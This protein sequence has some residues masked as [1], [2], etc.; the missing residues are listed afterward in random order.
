MSADFRVLG[1]SSV[2]FGHNGA[3]SY[4]DRVDEQNIL[5]ADMQAVDAFAG[6]VTG[7][8]ASSFFVHGNLTSG[9]FAGEVVHAEYAPVARVIKEVVAF[10]RDN[11]DALVTSV[12]VQLSSSA[13]WASIYS[14]A[15]FRPNVSASIGAGGIARS[16]AQSTSAWNAGQVMRVVLQ[17]VATD[18]KDLSVNVIWKPS[19]S[20]SA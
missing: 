5:N 10:A 8:F 7:S 16:S 14:N 18:Q 2:D 3:L 20:Y 19:G 11:G 15:S 13:G 9:S 4:P 12:D 6:Q 1:L 17:S